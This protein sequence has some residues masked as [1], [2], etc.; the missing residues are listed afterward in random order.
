MKAAVI[1]KNRPIQSDIEGLSQV[2]VLEKGFQTNNCKRLI[3]IDIKC[4]MKTQ[5]YHTIMRD[6]KMI[7]YPTSVLIAF[8]HFSTVSTICSNNLKEVAG[9]I[10]KTLTILAQ[11]FAS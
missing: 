8:S 7:C 5:E 9:T 3:I 1:K 10:W 2:K 6:A 4:Y 11:I